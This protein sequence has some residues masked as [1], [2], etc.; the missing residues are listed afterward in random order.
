MQVIL[1]VAGPDGGQ[2]EALLGWLLESPKLSGK[3]ALARPDPLDSAQG[4]ASDALAVAVSSGGTVT[5]LALCLRTWIQAHYAQR[6][7]SV[8]IEL[9]AADG[10]KAVIDASNAEDAEK[11]LRQ[12]TS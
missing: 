3:V 4:A 7:T 8:H 1:R 10:K 9:T 12:V 11:I 5:A 2:A 6:K